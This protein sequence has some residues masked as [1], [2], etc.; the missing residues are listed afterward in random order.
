MC[1]EIW[2]E[3]CENFPFHKSNISFV[4]HP[5]IDHRVNNTDVSDPVV[6]HHIDWPNLIEES[7]FAVPCI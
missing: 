7:S 3:P 1:N 6:L 2:T 4:F 5:G